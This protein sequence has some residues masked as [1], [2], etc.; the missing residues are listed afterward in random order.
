MASLVR[1]A[2][3]KVKCP[4]CDTIQAD[5]WEVLR[6]TEASQ[7]PCD[8][9]GQQFVYMVAECHHCEA[10]NSFSSAANLVP[11]EVLEAMCLSCNHPIQESSAPEDAFDG[12]VRA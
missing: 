9:C 5:P 7:I 2:D 1:D 11:S 6:A 8:A 3:G 4:H 10:E 12:Q